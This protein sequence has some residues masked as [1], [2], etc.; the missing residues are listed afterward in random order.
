M[1]DLRSVPMGGTLRGFRGEL[2]GVLV[3]EP[4]EDFEHLAP[5]RE[6]PAAALLVTLHGL[7]ELAFGLGVVALAGRR[8]DESATTAGIPC[9]GRPE[10]LGGGP[11][12]GPALAFALDLG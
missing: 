10:G 11:A 1:G 5:G 6:H 3:P 12:V 8:V 4:L 7:H 9:G 2:L